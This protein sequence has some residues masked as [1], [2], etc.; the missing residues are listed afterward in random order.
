M[1]EQTSFRRL[2]KHYRQAAG[3]S[4]E[5]LAARAGLSARA[6]SDLERGLYR[7]PRFD[8]L[9]LLLDALAL[10]EPQQA[11]LRAAA[12]PEQATGVPEAREPAPTLPSLPLAPRPLIGRAAEQAHLLRLV[13]SAEGRLVTITGPSGVGKTRLA[14]QVAHELAGDF[15]DGVGLVALAPLQAP[16]L[17]PEV[18][19]QRLHLREQL[20]TPRLEQV[21]A[22]LQPQHCLLVLD[23]Y[24]HLLDATAFV[25]D[26]LAA[27]P[28]LHVLVT[29]RAPLRLQ[30][31]Q[32]VPLAPL[33]PTDA[34][35]L[36][37]ARAQAVRPSGAYEEPLVAAICERV[38]RL[39]LAIELAAM[40]V[41]LLSLPDLLARLS[42]RLALLRG[43]ARDLPARQQTMRDAIAWSYELLSAEQQRWFR[44]LGVFV[45]GWTLEAAEAIG[46]AE[47]DEGERPPEEALLALAAL[48]D[49]SLVQVEGSTEGA[50]R[51]SLLELIREYA[52]EQLRAAGEEAC[53]RRHASF[54]AQ[55]A[56]RVVPYGPGQGAA[57][58][59]V[60]QEFANARA[61]L[62][63]AAERQEATLGLRLVT[64]FGAFWYSHGQLR[65]A[66]AWLERL[67]AL[68]QPAEVP[69][70]L[71]VRR[72]EALHLFGDVLLGVG[73]LERAKAVATAALE[74][75]RQRGDPCLM[76]MA[77]SVLGIAAKA[78]GRLEEAAACFAESDTHA[79]QTDALSIRGVA[80]RS[81][82]EVAWLQGDLELATTLAEEGRVGALAAGIPFVVAGQTTMLGR[83]AH[84]QGNYSLA[85]ARYREALALY[86]TFSN[87]TYTAWCLEGLASTV[88]AEGRY[89]QAAHVCAAAAALRAQAQTP[90]PPAE[91]E[92]F[93][94]TVARA[95]A[96]LG[97]AAFEAEWTV[98]TVLTQQEAIAYALSEACA[99]P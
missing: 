79:R 72:A 85:K 63:W 45:G 5:A 44:A 32:V 61:A 66:E 67:L 49:A 97:E 9:Q 53:R 68:D 28:R 60:S 15:P 69:E 43:G 19:A 89:E 2:L 42:E 17:V 88:C 73:K 8:T 31:E 26:L 35:A 86:R 27:C 82:V 40:Q 55:L 14:V 24:E 39:P 83:L 52:L 4:Q 62:Q 34:V 22:F 12:Q 71:V 50:T 36:F 90:L 38:D 58:A 65:E 70:A 47:G 78:E 84:Q 16:A 6:I 94:Q 59:Q 51:F 37:R 54:Y 7:R 93:E 98:G 23:N 80:S 92:A 77:W 57:A 3:L 20:D 30:A 87:P 75:A 48:I 25:A 11:L 95:Q 10:P 81:R 74:A 41:R 91:R 18:V 1:T 13:R 21:R 76:S 64:A 46:W 33:T 29:S 56:E 99:G 96:A